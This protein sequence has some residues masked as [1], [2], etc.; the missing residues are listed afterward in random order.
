VIEL[1]GTKI[2]VLH[3]FYFDFFDFCMSYLRRVVT[4]H[5]LNLFL[6]FYTN[7]FTFFEYFLTFIISRQ[8]LTCVHE[9]DKILLYVKNPVE[10]VY[11]D[12]INGVE[13]YKPRRFLLY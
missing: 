8:P 13:V 4:F 2:S 11:I 7:I 5:G 10:V 3:F 1:A 12:V 6:F 9:V